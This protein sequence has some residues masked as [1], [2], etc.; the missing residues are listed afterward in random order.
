LARIFSLA[1]FLKALHIIVTYSGRKH[2]E[3]MASK[4]I[5]TANRTADGAVVYLGPKRRWAA[6]LGAS[7][8]FTEEGARDEA[9]AWAKGEE[10]VVCDPYSL[11]V[12]VGADGDIRV[13]SARERI[14]AAGP[15]PVLE[16]LGLA[17]ARR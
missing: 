10:G 15:D 14:R 4:Y 1:I 9:L 2:G 6:E 17:G 8:V 16:R 3:R 13:R 11:A 5:V 7:V 12:D